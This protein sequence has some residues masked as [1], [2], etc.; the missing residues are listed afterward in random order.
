MVIRKTIIYGSSKRLITYFSNA[1]NKELKGFKNIFVGTIQPG[2]VF[3]DLLLNNMTDDGMKI[4]N[5]LGNEVDYVAQKVVPKIL[6]GKRHVKVMNTLQMIGR[7]LKSIVIKP[8]R[9]EH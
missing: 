1:C 3:T 6:K 2:M 4:A 9:K 8:H 5:I 7:F